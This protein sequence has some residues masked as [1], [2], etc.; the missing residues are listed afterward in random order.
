M[1]Y[2]VLLPTREGGQYLANAV[3]SIL[4]DPYEDM[5]LVV[6]DNANTDDTPRILASFAGDSRLKVVR[7]D[8]PI[9][10]HDNWNLTVKESTGDYI[11]MLGDD[12]Y[13]LSGYFDKMDQLLEQYDYPDCI[14]YNYCVYV[15][16][17]AIGNKVSYYSLDAFKFGYGR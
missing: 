5:E 17:N 11:L 13:I 1:K 6:S 8:E 16:P 4:S 3:R 14:T 10:V 9:P 15:F 7:T 2:S 12:D